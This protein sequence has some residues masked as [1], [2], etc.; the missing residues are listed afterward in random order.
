MKRV[1]QHLAEAGW[2]RIT[3]LLASL[4]AIL[5][6]SVTTVAVHGNPTSQLSVLCYAFWG[7]MASATLLALLDRRK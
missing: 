2:T 7:I 3:R 1:N 4:L 5:A 6:V